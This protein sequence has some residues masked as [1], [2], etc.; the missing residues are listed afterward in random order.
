MLIYWGFCL[1]LYVIKLDIKP[2]SINEAY[3]GRRRRT[4]KYNVF[5][6]QISFLLPKLDL[7]KPPYLI[8]FEFGF[9]SL[10]SDGDNCIKAAQDCIAEKYGFN[11]KLIKRW[12]VDVEQVPKGS[13][14]IKFK[15]ETLVK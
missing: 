12:I 10:A 1:Y 11:D 3:T 14:Y 4:E 9:S 15:I 6:R 8:H 13:E 7:P 2:I 5:K